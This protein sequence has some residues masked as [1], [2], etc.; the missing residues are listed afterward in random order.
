MRYAPTHY[1]GRPGDKGQ[2]MEIG[3]T[4]AAPHKGREQQ[5]SAIVRARRKRKLEHRFELISLG[6]A[7]PIYAQSI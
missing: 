2:V 7:P 6:H 3:N 1:L 4:A 5:V